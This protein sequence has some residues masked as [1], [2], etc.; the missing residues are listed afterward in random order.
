MAVGDKRYEVIAPGNETVDA[1][2]LTVIGSDA[3]QT[4]VG[5]DATGLVLHGIIQYEDPT[6]AFHTD[7]FCMRGL[8]GG[9]AFTI[10][11]GEEYNWHETEY[12]RP[13]A[14]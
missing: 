4:F 11:G 1:K 7:S 14:G 8:E 6:G 10:D 9:T 12:P 2:A 13:K 3:R 5:A